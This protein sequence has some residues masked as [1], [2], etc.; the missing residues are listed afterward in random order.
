M[1]GYFDREGL[2]KL[3]EEVSEELRW[4]R[5]RAQIYLTGG[6]AMSLAYQPV[7][8]APLHSSGDASGLTALFVG[9]I[10][11]ICALLTPCQAGADAALGATR[12][13]TMMGWTPPGFTMRQDGAS[14]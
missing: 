11:P 14:D 2:L 12:G 5:T 7:A 1:R 9:C 4:S 8:K 3:L 10:C 6:A 13:S